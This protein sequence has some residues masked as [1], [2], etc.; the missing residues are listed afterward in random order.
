M[1]L[2]VLYRTRPGQNRKA[3]PDFYSR[4]VALASLRRSVEESGEAVRISFVADGGLPD[5]LA[6]AVREGE[7]V[8]L[9]SGGSAAA[10]MRA[11]VRVAEGL[12]REDD[13]DVLYWLAEDDY[14]YRPDA[15]ASLLAAAAAIP[16]A[17]Y[18]TLYTADGSAWFATHPSQPSRDVPS[19][20]GGPVEVHG[21]VW[22]RVRGTTSTFGVRSR[23][24]REDG[25]LL[26]LA[27]R[28][29]SPIDGATWHSVQG[30]EPY[31]WRHLHRDLAPRRSVRGVGKVVVKPVMRVVV[32]LASHRRARAGRVLVAPREDLAMHLEVGLLPAG[33]DWERLAEE[34]P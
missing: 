29:G 7:R 19:L 12:A 34:T 32:N 2:H 18:L 20:P 21:S 10:S 22:D 30:M 25:W 16:E 26:R 17:D 28:A 3:R 33:G 9:V 15:V 23:A 13:G 4:S 24:L 27:S 14:L 6:G 5:E 8:H 1:R 11:C 31:S